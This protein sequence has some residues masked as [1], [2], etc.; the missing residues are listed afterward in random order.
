[1]SPALRRLHA[2]LLVVVLL[3]AASACGQGVPTRA[4]IREKRINDPVRRTSVSARV[5][6]IRLLAIRI[7]RPVGDSAGGNAGLFLTL[8]SSA[9]EDHLTE[10][11][12]DK[13]SSVVVREGAGAASEE[14]DVRVPADGTTSMQSSHG[15]H[16][17]LV[18]LTKDLGTK[19]FL[20]VTFGFTHAGTVRV[21]VFVSN[22]D[23][24]VVPPA[25]DE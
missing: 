6:N 4:E 9:A 22:V 14:I 24:S 5:G 23:H 10:V 8:T 13:A 3:A 21:N 17:E 2:L 19:T 20:P 25:R 12:T 7:E 11:S 1:M 15:R 18:E 16:L